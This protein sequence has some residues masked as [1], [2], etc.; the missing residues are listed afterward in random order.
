MSI[1]SEPACGAGAEDVTGGYCCRAPRAVSTA[2]G[3]GRQG[4][5]AGVLRC[6]GPQGCDGFRPSRSSPLTEDRSLF[7]GPRATY[8]RFRLLHQIGAGSVGPVF[9][10]EDGETRQRVVIKVIRVGLPP[11]KVAAL[12][13]A[14][15]ALKAHWPAH[16]GLAPMIET[17]VVDVEPYVVTP[18]IDG[19]SLD[20]ALRD[21]GPAHLTDAL[22]RLR[23]LAEALDAAAAAGWHHGSLHL[24]DI[25]VSV[26]QT[27]LTGMGIAPLLE[28]VGVRPPVRRPYSAPEVV[29]GG[30]IGR[31]TDQFA[32]AAIAHE[33]L[34]GRRLSGPGAAGFHVPAATPQGAEA[35]REVFERALA[36]DADDRFPSASAF[37]EALGARIGDVAERRATR[38]GRRAAAELPR[39][40]FDD[41]PDE[42]PSADD[43]R[44]TFAPVVDESPAP[45][46]AVTRATEPDDLLVEDDEVV[47]EDDD[48]V[49]AD[50]PRPSAGTMSLGDAHESDDLVGGFSLRQASDGVDEDGLDEPVLAGG[51][52]SLD[53]EDPVGPA[54]AADA[55]MAFEYHETDAAPDEAAPAP[56]DGGSRWAMWA[57]VLVL[58]ALA[59]VGGG[60]GLLRWGTPSVAPAPAAQTS[61]PAPVNQT[62][63]A[64]APAASAPAESAAPAASSSTTATAAPS[65]APEPAAEA[66]QPSPASSPA[67]RPAAAPSSGS[68]AP[69]AAP[70]AAAP[71]TRAP[72][73]AP[74]N[75]RLLVRS[76]PAGAEVFVNGE[77]RGVTPLTLRGLSTGTYTVRLARTGFVAAEQRVV[78]NRARPSRS[79]DVALR[80]V[81]APRA[82]P[83]TRPAA[84]ARRAP[85]RPPAAAPA[86]NG[87]L[88]VESR[89]AGARV[90]VDGR[91]M[92]VT[93]LTIPAL[94]A[95]SHTVRLER[96]GYTSIATTTRVEPGAR[97]R[98]AVTLTAERPDR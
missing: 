13:S 30:V 29:Q 42:A 71:A 63:A 12:A 83:P 89:P 74:S 94:A 67:A 17:G 37:V 8:G 39:L 52:P 51:G 79:L 25:M 14:L 70:A 93:P 47:P 91:A 68:S 82:T 9:R 88:V 38:S 35:L 11:E 20:V 69:L 90:V 6:F 32:L 80:R 60:W 87:S 45:T 98:V 18:W 85:A 43:T 24:R 41:T 28:K 64:G 65:P 21:Y 95:G 96:A 53:D 34:S 7:D 16:P 10:G 54:S 59:I 92:G 75:G 56:A 55:P 72:A 22:P 31:G 26:E 73:A 49:P 97:A 19:D 27:V 48:V 40:S 15:A 58:G 84:P 57:G 66:A 5:R 4:H 81:A 2:V 50:D 78:L 33:W 36:D 46:P 61:A 23:R 86:G 3:G 77:R 1:A 44:L 62:P 76:T